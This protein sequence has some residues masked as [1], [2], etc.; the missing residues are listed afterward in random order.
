MFLMDVIIWQIYLT[1]IKVIVV[2]DWHCVKVELISAM[3]FRID[4]WLNG[5]MSLTD[6]L[7]QRN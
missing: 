5:Q 4:A 2:I 7:Q 3:K 6:H 1:L